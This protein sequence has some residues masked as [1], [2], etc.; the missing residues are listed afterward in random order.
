MPLIPKHPR[1]APLEPPFGPEAEQVLQALGPPLAL[2]RLFA[3]RPP[4][5]RAIHGWGA[6]Y[7]SRDLALT[8][9]QRELVIDRTTARCGADYEWSIHIAVFAGKVGLTAAQIASLACGS[10]ADECWRDPAERAILR[11]VDAL[12][13]SHDLADGLWTELIGA[14]GEEGAIDVLLVCGWYHAISFVARAA[15][16][17]LETGTESFARTAA[18]ARERAG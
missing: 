4:R 12:H 15:R 16:L 1:L 14:V 6:Y 5:A 9:R 11:A 18:R 3:R 13:D 10:A 17:P 8:L 2:F 7:M